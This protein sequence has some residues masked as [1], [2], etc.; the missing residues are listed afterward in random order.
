MQGEHFVLSFVEGDSGFFDDVARALR[1][2]VLRIRMRTAD[3]LFLVLM[4][5][6]ISNY[7]SLAMSIGD[8]LDDL[9][10]EL[11]AARNERDI[12]IQLQMQRRRYMELKRTV[13]PL[14]EQFQRLLRSDSGL[15]A[16]RAAPSST[17]SATTCRTPCSWSRGAVRP[18][19]RSWT[20][21]SRTTTCA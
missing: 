13:M 14:R 4:N 5:G 11:L 21:T 6:V 2:N 15:S 7:V 18:S 1:D 20:S 9:E 17:T 16:R 8:E 19:R 3:Y 12:G 10:S